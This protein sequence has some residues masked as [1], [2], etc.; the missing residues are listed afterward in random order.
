MQAYSSC[1]SED[2]KC[3]N[4]VSPTQ[5]STDDHS[6]DNY[7]KMKTVGYNA[8]WLWDIY[9]TFKRSKMSQEEFEKAEYEG[10]NRIIEK[11]REEQKAKV[12]S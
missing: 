10:V 3:A 4:S 12:V 7:L 11:I 5:W 9:N 8:G 1:V 6:L 2:P